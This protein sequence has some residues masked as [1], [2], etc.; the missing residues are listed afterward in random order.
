MERLPMPMPR[1]RATNTNGLEIDEIARLAAHAETSYTRQ[2]LTSV[3]MTLQGI[4]AETIAR[5][6]GCSRVS[7]WRYVN[8]WNGQDVEAAA[9]HRGG[10]QSSFTEEMLQDIDDALRNRSPRDHGYS[11]NRWDMFS[12]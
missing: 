5:T 2:T 11:K 8:R 9:D 7:V 12:A 3:V 6:L 10:S 4:P 1:M